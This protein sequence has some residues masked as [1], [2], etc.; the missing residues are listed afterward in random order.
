ME[1][2]ISSPKQLGEILFERLKIISDPKKTKTKQ[3]ATG[4]EILQQLEDKHP[5]VSKVLEYRSLR[6]LLSTYVEALPLLV[7]AQNRESYTPPLIRHLV[8]TGRLSSNNPNLQNI[9]IRE[10][11]GREIRRAFIPEKADHLFFRPTILRS[12]SGSWRI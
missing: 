8:T 6:K 9:P 12:N 4:E 10:E 11:R 2:N 7:K 3:Y 5:I 1:F